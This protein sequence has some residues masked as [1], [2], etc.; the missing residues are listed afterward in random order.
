M[1]MAILPKTI[2][3]FDEIPIKF[4]WHLSERLKNQP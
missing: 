4:Q 1:K 2:C 3:V